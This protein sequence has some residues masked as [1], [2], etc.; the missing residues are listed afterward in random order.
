MRPL[1]PGDAAPPIPGAEPTDVPGAVVFY[2]VTCPTC[3]MAAPAMERLSAVGEHRFVAVA[4]D[5]PDSAEE[6]A[7]RYGLSFRSVPDTAPFELSNAYG[8]RT[9]P[10]A[11][12]VEGGAITDV[13]ESWDREGWNRAARGL[14]LDA[15][16]HEGDGLPPFRPG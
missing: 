2:K 13:V 8:I 16:S 7:R 14:G 9:V 4:Q 5:P 15:V 11:F 6:F 12:V 10:T 3:Q 1:Q